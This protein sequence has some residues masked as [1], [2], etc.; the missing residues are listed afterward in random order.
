M[1]MTIRRLKRSVQKVARASGL[2]AEDTALVV[3]TVATIAR[4]GKVHLSEVARGLVGKDEA[5]IDPERAVSE[6]LA[7]PRSTLD[8]LPDGWLQ[9]VA[10]TAKKLSFVTVDG[11]DHA[12]PYGKAFEHL[13]WVRDASDPDKRIVPGY[14]SVQ[15]DA[16][17]KLHRM[18]PL[19]SQVFS[20]LA[21]E[22]KSWW[23]TFLRPM[24]RV[25]ARLG[26]EHTWLFDRGFDAIDFLQALMALRIHW[27]VRQTQTRHVLLGNGQWVPMHLLAAGLHK[28][29][30]IDVP[31]VDK[32]SHEQKFA[33]ASF[34]FAPVR[35]PNIDAPLT[36]IVIDGGREEDIVLLTNAH[37][38]HADQAEEIVLAYLRRWGSEEAT[39]AFKQLTGVEDF[40]VR[41]WESIKRLTCLAMITWGIQALMLIKRTRDAV[42][43]IA[44]VPQFFEDVLL[45]NYRLWRGIADALLT[46]A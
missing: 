37:I 28:P 44:R 23:D 9:T 10:P 20:T 12:K 31:Y 36:M 25:I 27:V 42:R 21:P 7:A 22:Y 30:S 2:N 8:G 46:G 43:Y 38:T 5:L 39:R 33:P 26:R 6:Q 45:K 14:W 13:D 41:K 3:Q 40:R 1:G 35:L 32:R 11:S 18:L 4:T 15:I 34:G 29:H 19:V 24:L 17:D 16:L